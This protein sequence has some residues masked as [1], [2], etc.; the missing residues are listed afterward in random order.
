MQDDSKVM[1]PLK[2]DLTIAGDWARLY[3]IKTQIPPPW[4]RGEGGS[5]PLWVNL[6]QNGY[7]DT[8]LGPPTPH[9]HRCGGKHANLR[10]VRGGSGGVGE[11]NTAAT[12]RVE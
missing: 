3:Q 1:R 7:T 4:K 2:P 9:K 12:S 6:G 8:A 10:G 5:P 11:P